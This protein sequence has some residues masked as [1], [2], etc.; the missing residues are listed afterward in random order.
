M[1]TKCFAM[2]LSPYNPLSPKAI[3]LVSRTDRRREVA[4]GSDWWI[5]CD[6]SKDGELASFC[7]RLNM[8]KCC[9]AVLGVDYGLKATDWQE[10]SV[11]LVKN[12]EVFSL[13]LFLVERYGLIEI[14]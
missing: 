1:T 13:R 6:Y 8:Y 11:L 5:V 7:S 4:V 10:Q 12:I 14:P 9:I 3:P 2:V